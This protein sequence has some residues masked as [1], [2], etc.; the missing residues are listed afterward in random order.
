MKGFR[1]IGL[2]ALPFCILLVLFFL[3]LPLE[4]RHHLLGFKTPIFSFLSESNQGTNT[5]TAKSNKVKVY[6]PSENY[7]FRSLIP[8]DLREVETVI[9]IASASH[10]EHSHLPVTKV[11]PNRICEFYKGNSCFVINGSKAG[12][13]IADDISLME[14][15]ATDYTPKYAVLYQQSQQIEGY[16]REALNQGNEQ[17]IRSSFFE[18]TS[19]RALFQSTSAYQ[20]LSDYIGGNIKLQGLLVDKLPDQYIDRYKQE[21]MDFVV[22]C[23]QNNIIPILTTFA[24]SHQ[25]ANLDE[26]PQNLKTN[27]VRYSVYMSPKGWIDTVKQFNAAITEIA[28]NKGI[29]LIDLASPLSGKPWLFTDFVHF[30]E[31]GHK[32]VA[33]ILSNDIYLIDSEI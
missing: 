23:N 19:A 2:L 16:Q 29:K 21:V 9:W 24:S 11:F 28:I 20:H 5:N 13:G 12:I 27:F 30:N 10:A 17:S 6:G 15:Y 31:D 1:K 8:G 14:K 18:A 3:E 26:M 32:Q 7:P 22:W 25:S 4:Y 33:K